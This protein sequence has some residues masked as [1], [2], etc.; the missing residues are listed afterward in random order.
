MPKHYKKV[1]LSSVSKKAK[2]MNKKKQ[3]GGMKKKTA[4][5]KTTHCVCSKKHHQMA[6]SMLTPAQ[7]KMLIRPIR[8]FNTLPV[9]M[10]QKGM[11]HC[12]NRC[13]QCGGN[14]FSNAFKSIGKALTKPSTY[15]SLASIP[16]GVFNP[17]AG[18]GLSV[19]SKGLAMTGNGKQPMLV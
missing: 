11:G 6:G 1:N 7:M 3:R 13:G 4:K 9:K 19:A 17:A 18:I 12:G 10:R 5:R 8:K 2:K 16:A 14:W 15:L